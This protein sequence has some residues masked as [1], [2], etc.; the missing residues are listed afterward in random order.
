VA[1]ACASSSTTTTPL[2]NVSA[3]AFPEFVQPAIPEAFGR[4]PA[5]VAGVNRGWRF[6]EAGD[7]GHAERAFPPS[8]RS[9]M[10]FFPAETA[11]GYLELA[12]K[13]PKAAL[14]HF[15]KALAEDPRYVS[16]LVGGGQAFLALG[17]ETDALF[18]FQSAVAVDPSLSD[19][20]RRVE[21]LQFRGLGQDLSTA[22]PAA[23][24]RKLG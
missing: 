14:P 3:T 19:V 20:R 12:R 10:G 11:L 9:S 16:A 8:L 6:L 5:A 21:V 18:A 4:Y 13:E 15:E 2:P 7:I 22:R 24:A 23:Q 17:R 1:A